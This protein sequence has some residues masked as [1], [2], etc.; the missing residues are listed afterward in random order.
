VKKILSRIKNALVPNKEYVIYDQT[1]LPAP[2]L[3]YCGSKFGDDAYF[4]KTAENEAHRI[5][6]LLPCDSSGHV[7]DIGCG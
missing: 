3:R 7:L 6:K 1:R 4:V 2:R 5:V